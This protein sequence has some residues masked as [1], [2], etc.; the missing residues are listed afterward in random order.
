MEVAPVR[1]LLVLAIVFPAALMALR[2]PWVGVILW[3][4]LSIMNPHRY[5]WGI[6]YEAPLAAIAAGCTLIGLLATKERQ[7]PFQGPPVTIFVMLICWIT[8]SWLGGYD[9]EGEYAQWNKVMKIDFMTVVAL[10]LLRTRLQIMAFIYVTVGSLAILGA[11]G[12]IFTLLS[13]GSYRVWGPPESFIYDNNHFALSLIMTIPLLYFLQHTVAKS[14]QK[15]LLIG[16]ALL[17]VA[18]A[19]GSY[20]RGAFLAIGAMTLVLWWRSDKKLAVGIGIVL[21]AVLLLP[22]MPDAWWDRMSTINTYEEDLSAQGRLNGWYVATQVALHNFFGGGM[23]Y[24]YPIYFDLY[25]LYNN[26]PIAAHSIYFQILGNHGFI[27]LFLFLALWLATF[28]WAGWLRTKAAGKAETAWAAMLGAMVQVSLVGYAV[29]GAFLS[30][31]YFDLPYNMMVMVVVARRWVERKAWE[32]DPPL[33]LLEAL[34][35]KKPA[36]APNDKSLASDH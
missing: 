14:W 1:D 16:I 10:C 29:G 8:I 13:G 34:S 4:W 11:K 18:S 2:Q 6:A 22:L 30:L 23:A 35:L 25:G 36:P 17:C 15:T 28:R 12:G 21:V 19:L 33:T 5:S 20:S 7:S 9:T 24:Q 32:T 27:G 26:N 31:A 3:T